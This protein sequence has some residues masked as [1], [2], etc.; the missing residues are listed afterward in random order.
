MSLALLV[1][2]EAKARNASWTDTDMDHWWMCSS[3]CKHRLT[4]SV[5]DEQS[6]RRVHGEIRGKTN[7]ILGEDLP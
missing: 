3:R 4:S 5:Q 7:M 1:D 2:G 6:H